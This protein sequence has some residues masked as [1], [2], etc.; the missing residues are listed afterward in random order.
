MPAPSGPPCRLSVRQVDI[1][2][3]KLLHYNWHRQQDLLE[4]PQVE[5]TTSTMS[6][7]EL[8]G[9]IPEKSPGAIPEELWVGV[10]G[11]PGGQPILCSMTLAH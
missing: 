1:P 9:V 7:G 4:K 6:I 8:P 3:L 2:G 11:I 10:G 5:S